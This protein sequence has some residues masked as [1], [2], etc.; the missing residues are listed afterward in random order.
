MSRLSLAKPK[1]LLN[2][3][4]E[5]ILI[6]HYAY[7]TEKPYVHWTKRYILFHNKHHSAEM[8]VAENL[9]KR[10]FYACG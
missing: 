4:R 5:A 9:V 3:F 8:G 6:K 2:Q 10:T 1:R 7:A